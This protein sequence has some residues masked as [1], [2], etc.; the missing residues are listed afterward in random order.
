MDIYCPL[1]ERGSEASSDSHHFQIIWLVDKESYESCTL[2]EQTSRRV[3]IS[4]KSD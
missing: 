3:S 1:D 2:N 4:S